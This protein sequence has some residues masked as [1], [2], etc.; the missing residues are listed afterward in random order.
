MIILSFAY[1]PA[2]QNYSIMTNQNRQ[3]QPFQTM[4]FGPMRTVP[5][6]I[7]HLHTIGP[8]GNLVG[9]F[10]IKGDLP[11]FWRNTLSVSTEAAFLQVANFS[12]E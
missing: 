10:P 8:N 6:W 3:Y 1:I 7:P 2:N 9:S 12:P 5:L 4:G 11:L